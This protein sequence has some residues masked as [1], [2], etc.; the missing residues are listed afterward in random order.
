M[1]LTLLFLF[2]VFGFPAP[3]LVAENVRGI[4]SVAVIP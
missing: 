4:Q 3:L 1:K 2:L